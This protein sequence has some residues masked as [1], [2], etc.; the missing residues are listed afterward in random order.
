[1]V[2]PNIALSTPIPD[3]IEVLLINGINI[4]FEIINNKE[5]TRI[6]KKSVVIC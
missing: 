5:I 3:N 6:N 2:Q 1:M 4:K